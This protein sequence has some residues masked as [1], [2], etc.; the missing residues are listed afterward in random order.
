MNK[1]YRGIFCVGFPFFSLYHPIKVIGRENIPEGGA[2]VCANHSSMSDPCFAAVAFTIRR[3]L[4]I[5]SKAS[6]MRVPLLGKLLKKAGM[7]GI[8]RGKADITAVKTAIGYLKN[9][10][11]VMMFPEGTR[12]RGNEDVDAKNGAAMFA[13]RCGVPVV[14]MY[15]PTKKPP[16]KRLTVV[17]GE[18]YYMLP[19]EKRAKPE[20]YH[21]LADELMDKIY[22]LGE[23]NQL[24]G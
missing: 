6:V 5:M 14:P 8:E 23:N 15:I 13:V 19:G 7:F 1:W 11:Y 10:E 20:Q 17:I 3:Q 22:A 2:L 21:Q 9:G 24:K 4:H 18:P 16:F 12:V